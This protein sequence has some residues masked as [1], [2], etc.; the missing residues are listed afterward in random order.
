[1]DHCPFAEPLTTTTH[2]LA[3]QGKYEEVKQLCTRSLAVREKCQ[4]PDHP[5][6]A[7]ALNN[8]ALSMVRQARVGCFD[9]SN[10]HDCWCEV[11][12]GVG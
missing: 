9:V 4:G 1:M 12:F 11:L 10:V 5:G 8:L 7:A 6:V 2:V 3:T